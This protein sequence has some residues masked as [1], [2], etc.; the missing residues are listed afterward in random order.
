MDKIKFVSEYP[1]D[2]YQCGLK[3][4]DTV[5]LKRDIVATDSRGKPSGKIHPAGEVWQV[6]PGARSE[7][8]VVWFLQA[9]GQRHTWDDDES[10]FDTFELMK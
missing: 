2:R 8:V 1:I 7:P 5:R 6:L 10:I 9:D 4:G 3:A